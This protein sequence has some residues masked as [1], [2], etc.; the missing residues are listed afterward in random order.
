[1]KFI[2]YYNV[3]LFLVPGIDKVIEAIKYFKLDMVVYD[4]EIRYNVITTYCMVTS[5]CTYYIR[6]FFDIEKKT[7]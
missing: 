4:F 2:D 3:Y 5:E 7:R 1:M 6:L